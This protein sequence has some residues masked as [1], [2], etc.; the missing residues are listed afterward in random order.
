MVLY[1]FLEHLLWA[2]D[3]KKTQKKV[4]V[5]TLCLQWLAYILITILESSLILLNSYGPYYVFPF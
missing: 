2:R 1:E 3:Q 4:T 5:K